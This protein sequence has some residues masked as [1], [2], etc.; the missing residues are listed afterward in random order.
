MMSSNLH[1]G[2]QDKDVEPPLAPLHWLLGPDFPAGVEEV[3]TPESGHHLFLT[4]GELGRVLLGELKF[5]VHR[6]IFSQIVDK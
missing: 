6:M 4:H 1:D 2:L 5:I 3:L